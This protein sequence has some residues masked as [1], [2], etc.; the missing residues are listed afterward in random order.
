MLMMPFSEQMK[1]KGI[2]VDI[3]EK[4]ILLLFGFSQI[5]DGIITIISLGYWNT[6]CAMWAVT[7]L[8]RYR[9]R[10]WKKER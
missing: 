6:S 8:A 10:N 7:I 4:L 1:Q 5:A 3:K 2:E 9:D